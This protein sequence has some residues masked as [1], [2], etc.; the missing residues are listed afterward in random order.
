MRGSSFLVLFLFNLDQLGVLST[1]DRQEI[2]KSLYLLGLFVCLICVSMIFMKIC[3]CV[4][5]ERGWSE[6]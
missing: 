1:G 2:T 3:M 6:R 4:C 5:V